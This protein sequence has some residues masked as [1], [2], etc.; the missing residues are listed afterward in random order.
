MQKRDQTLWVVA[1][2]LCYAGG[3]LVALTALMV[4]PLHRE[5]P[6]WLFD[7]AIILIGVGVLIGSFLAIRSTNRDQ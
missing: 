5:P 3:I 1:K 6:P 2:W 7:S 4:G